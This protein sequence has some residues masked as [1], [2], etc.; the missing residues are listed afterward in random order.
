MRRRTFITVLGGAAAWP[1]VARAQ[2]PAGPVIGFLGA[3]TAA[4]QTEWTAAFVRRLGELGWRE[5]RDITIEYRWA[6][7][8]RER[9]VEIAQQFV[10][11]NVD[12][13]VAA[14]SAQVLAAKEQTSVIPIV[15]PVAA[16]PIGS[17]IVPS[18]ARPGGNVTGLSLQYTDL[19]PKRVELIRDLVPTLSRLAIMVN[20]GAPGPVL[21]MREAHASAGTLGVEA[22][23]FEIRQP[24]DIEP[25]FTAL[26][27]WANGLYVCSDPLV[28]THR[29][30]IAALALAARLPSI[31]SFR[32]H[33]EAGGLLS[34][35]TS[36]PD[37]F[38]RAA[39]LVDKILRG[40]K[41]GDIP[42]EQPTRFELVIN[43]ET[44]KALG[45]EVP[46]TL[47]ARADE[48]IE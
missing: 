40:T 12:V 30:T 33:A 9:A 4:T 37:L 25:A 34:Y 31:H 6:E 16:D 3:N 1:L 44:A 42:V 11:R 21:E 8:L 17:G 29:H 26:T 20:A 27:R 5:G 32:E 13:I 39:E 28:G 10:R 43:L 22:R 47:L 35:G 23:T 19:A 46:P 15:F 45:I 7:G 41:P 36:F 18:L 14:G 48:V 2:Q 24:T 38:R